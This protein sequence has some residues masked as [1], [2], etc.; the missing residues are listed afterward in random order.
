[1]RMM[2]VN[3]AGLF[4]RHFHLS[5]SIDNLR[6]RKK[7][8]ARDATSASL[9][10]CA[11]REAVIA[12]PA[13][14]ADPIEPA[15]LAGNKP[16]DLRR[17]GEGYTPAAVFVLYY[18]RVGRNVD[19][20]L[21][22]ARKGDCLVPPLRCISDNENSRKHCC[23]C[24]F[25]EYISY[26]LGDRS[27]DLRSAEDGSMRCGAEDMLALTVV[28]QMAGQQKQRSRKAQREHAGNRSSGQL[29]R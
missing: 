3:Q 12:K 15:R 24:T 29:P 11:A 1:M 2:A 16:L 27:D 21:A 10:A 9:L 4:R 14:A 25:S 7:N 17:H 18:D 8:A 23:F 19:A 26:L 28:A 6:A 13:V 5:L 20:D 22:P